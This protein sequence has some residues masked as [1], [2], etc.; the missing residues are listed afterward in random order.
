MAILNEARETYG[1]RNV[2][3]SDGKIFIKDEKK[4]SNKPIVY[5]D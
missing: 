3:T 5:Y 1:F 4:P 2:W